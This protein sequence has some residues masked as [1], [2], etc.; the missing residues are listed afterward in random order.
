MDLAGHHFGIRWCVMG[1]SLGVF[2]IEGKR[3]IIETNLLG[4]FGPSS[5]WGPSSGI[6]WLVL[7]ELTKMIINNE[8]HMHKHYHAGLAKINQTNHLVFT[9]Y[10]MYTMHARSL[11]SSNATILPATVGTGVVTS[12]WHHPCVDL[13]SKI[14]RVCLKFVKY[15]WNLWKII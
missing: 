15:V 5:K 3:W 1:N 7:F 13:V 12:C 11:P 9:D 6:L 14:C 4:C 2:N 8:A 10:I